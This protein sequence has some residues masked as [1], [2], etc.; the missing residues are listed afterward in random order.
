[1]KNHISSL[2]RVAIVTLAA[3]P[4]LA[5]AAP[6]A[7]SAYYTDVT[8]SYVQDQTSQVM[9]QLNSILCFMGAMAP[10]QMVN[11]GDAS[12]NYVALI[13]KN[14]CD[15][16]GS[17]GQSNNTGAAYVP[18]VINSTRASSAADMLV[19]AWLTFTEQGAPQEIKV[20][21]TASQAPS[22]TLPYGVF[23]MDF[24]GNATNCALDKGY[25]NATTSGLSFF[26]SG[27]YGTDSETTRLQLNAT[28][29]TAGS[30]ATSQQY[31]WNGGGTNNFVFAYNT[32]YFVR[33]D[34]SGD[35]CFDRSP[36]NA[37]ES[38]WRYGL[39]DAA[40]ARVTRNSGFPIE[41][42]VGGVTS[43][44]YI[45]YYG[46]WTQ[47]TGPASG[48]TV[49]KVTY[50]NTGA[51]KTAY[52]L[53]KTGGKLMKYT[54]AIKTLADLN[55]VTFWYYANQPVGGVM[56]AGSQYELYWD[57][58]AGTFKISGKQN[59]TT[60]NMEPYAIHVTVPNTDMLAANQWGLWGWS[61]MMGGQFGIKGS[62]FA[63]LTTTP[64]VIKVVTQKQDVVYPTDYGTI[65]NLKCINDCPTV[66]L[67]A[68]SNA[69]TPTSST[70]FTNQGWTPVNSVSFVSYTLNPATGNMEAASVPV[71]ST[72]TTGI[73]AYGIRS[74][75]LV[76]DAQANAIILAKEASNLCGATGVGACDGAPAAGKG[77]NQG[78]VDFLPVPSS[79]YVWETGGQPWNQIAILTDANGPVIFEAPLQVSFTVPSATAADLAKY[80]T[81]AGATVSLQYGGFGDLWGIPNE[82]I[83]L[84]TNLACDFTQL[85]AYQ[86]QNFRWTSKF[87]IPFD[88]TNGVVTD[89]T[90]TYYAKP[91]DKEVRL[92]KVDCVA[93]AGGLSTTGLSSVVLPDATGW[94]DPATTVGTKPTV[95]AAPQVIH[96]VKQY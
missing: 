2:F 92:A 7:G 75:R 84:K 62:E 78:D 71:V 79:Y 83:D 65:G 47:G 11:S 35:L 37:D 41:Y 10:D 68:A 17:G 87:S 81:Y 70:P 73:N 63:L 59:N 77:F 86:Q 9:G 33:N 90:S 51:T 21:A 25:I 95:T 96:G 5:S 57:S 19:K 45:G 88:T 64:L 58:T 94:I 22:A 40:G 54:T 91:L 53:L 48:D 50:S 93:T 85:P 61:Q 30:G 6:A 8:N 44:G 16:K 82:C 74:G 14:T 60:N 1:M 67:I 23:R 76:T 15:S 24:C 52:T 36:A 31:S 34:G 55:K 66:A 20:Y 89:G 69:A 56:T 39:Y 28:S 42:T 72:A 38:V 29:S 13:D 4:A 3:F 18:A 27:T 49:Q 12:G 26:S 46:M 80:G 43:N 32:S